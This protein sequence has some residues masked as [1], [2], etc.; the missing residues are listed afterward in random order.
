M[1]DVPNVWTDGILVLDEVTG[2]SS[3]GSGFLLISLDI[4]WALV[5]GIMLIMVTPMVVRSSPGPLQTVQRVELWSGAGLQEPA[6][7]ISDTGFVPAIA[8]WHFHAVGPRSSCGGHWIL[9]LE[10]GAQGV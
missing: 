6:T 10:P 9:V 8:C 7:Q 3:S 5:G 1:P 4:V 2:V